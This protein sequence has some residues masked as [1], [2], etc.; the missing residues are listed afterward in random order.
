MIMMI[1]VVD[2]YKGGAF[3][4]KRKS[5]FRGQTT[6]RI[7][8]NKKP[9]LDGFRSLNSTKMFK[10]TVVLAAIAALTG[11]SVAAPPEG[12]CTVGQIYCGSTFLS[13][14]QPSM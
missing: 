8:L 9:L 2:G 3:V 4:A 13:T 6:R 5:K 1:G 14:P 10:L 12:T 7:R 11:S